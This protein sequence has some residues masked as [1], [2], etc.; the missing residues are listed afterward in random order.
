VIGTSSDSFAAGDHQRPEHARLVA[1]ILA[2]G[3]D[4][5][6][7]FSRAVLLNTADAA[8]RRAVPAGPRWRWLVP[9][10]VEVF[11]KHTDYA[12]GRSLLAAVPRGVAV[13]ARDRDDGQVRVIDGRYGDVVVIDPMRDDTP[14]R[15]LAGYVSVVVRRFASNFPGASLGADIAIASDLPRAAGLSSSSAVLVGVG[16]ALI[17]RAGLDARDE[18]C[19]AIRSSFDLAGYFGC[20]ENGLTYRNLE[21]GHGV[22]TE[23]GSEDH[24]AILSCQPGAVSQFGFVP[25]RH[26][27]D[28]RVPDAWRFVIASSGVRA[29]KAGTVRERYNR[30]S[31]AAHALVTT[32]NEFGG[33]PAT[34]L[35]A[36]LA[37]TPDAA[38]RLRAAL[39]GAPAAGFLSDDL[40]RRL[41]HFINE[42]ARVPEA[43]EA[44]RTADAGALGELAR[45]SQTDAETLLGN[46][47][48]ETS[49]LA[50]AALDCGALAASSFG[51]GFGGSVWAIV[52]EG[53]A[54]SYG[55]TWVGTY[56]A[57]FPS[58]GRTEWFPARPSPSAVELT[59]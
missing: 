17:R 19:Q 3:F 51:A 48:P 43:A 47:V 25:V 10:R 1:A 22:G 41:Q 16:L 12:G 52:P 34:S 46:Q 44:F 45:A 7:A 15:G 11:G 50:G 35:A 38:D 4:E 21:G 39:L 37:S 54:A 26:L 56:R 42:D 53:A 30:A 55:E 18:W 28:V 8:L 14:R 5:E 32:W 6:A 20:V 33:S 49:G 13:V 57:R 9:G 59:L 2:R 27:D 58:A 23:G 29:D 24:T 31:R 36:A 40:L